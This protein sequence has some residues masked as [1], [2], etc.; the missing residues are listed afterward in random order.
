MGQDSE[1]WHGDGKTPPR[2]PGSQSHSVG[3]IVPVLPLV[4]RVPPSDAARVDQC[5]RPYWAS[6][7]HGLPPSRGDSVSQGAFSSGNP[8]AHQVWR[9]LLHT[10]ETEHSL[11]RDGDSQERE[12][13]LGPFSKRE[14]SSPFSVNEQFP[15]AEFSAKQE[16]L[17]VLKRM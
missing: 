16:H 1:G 4:P 13:D 3:C 5:A 10:K 14:F 11:D 15:S 8:H 9:S 2:D 17:I 6:A 7:R 12:G